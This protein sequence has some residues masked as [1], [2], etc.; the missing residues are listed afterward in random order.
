MVASKIKPKFTKE[1]LTR[2]RNYVFKKVSDTDEAEE[3]F[4][5]VLAS[6][7]DSL[8][9]FQG[10]SQ[11]FT[12]LCGIANHNIA[13]YYR[14]RKIKTLLFSRF[15][16]LEAIA[17]EALT[18]DERVEK[19]ELRKE[20]K[21]VLSVLTEGYKEVLR[22]KYIDGFSVAQIAKKAKTTIKAVESKLT[23]AREA[24]RDRWQGE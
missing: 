18:P 23:R 13:D 14:K 4:Q 15:P 19:M 2:L 10:K 20:V 24:F 22:L 9:L 7:T 5:E 1:I 12:W 8:A 16:F 6:A 11:F 3:I 21:Q 17:S